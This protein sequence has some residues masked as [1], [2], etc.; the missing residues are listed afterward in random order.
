MWRTVFKCFTASTLVAVLSGCGFAQ[1]VADGTAST[2]QAIFYKQ[3]KT[4]HLDLNGRSAINTDVEEMSGLS[5]PVLVRVYQLKDSKALENAT[6]DELVSQGERVLRDDLLD[7]RVVVIKPG[8][9]AQL[10]TP[11]QG[12]A[13]YVAVVAL[14]RSPDVIENTWRVVLQRDDLEPDQARV[15]ELGDNR[16][17][18]Q[19]RA[20]G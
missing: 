11:L 7:E 2:A 8:E 13:R 1:K 15:L 19:H 12:D 14:F 18:L 16:L 3:V 5:V 9:A 20:E 6:Y 4:L 17:T 10:S